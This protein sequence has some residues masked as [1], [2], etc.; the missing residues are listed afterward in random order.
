M[1]SDREE[2]PLPS[3][4]FET[5]SKLDFTD[6]ESVTKVKATVHVG[7]GERAEPLWILLLKFLHRLICL[8][9]FGVRRDAFGKGWWI[10]FKVMTFLPF[11]LDSVFDID[12]IISLVGLY[13]Q[14]A[15]RTS[16]L[17]ATYLF[18]HDDRSRRSVGIYN[19]CHF[20][21]RPSSSKSPS[22]S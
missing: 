9:E 4:P 16:Q 6:G 1:V 5:G 8:E 13:S 3:H 14:S 7:V 22:A 10:G 15:G 12:K 19:G 21:Y 18:H 17:C 11:F 2:D 20:E